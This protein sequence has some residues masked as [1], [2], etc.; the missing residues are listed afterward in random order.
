MSKLYIRVTKLALS[1][2][3]TDH[4][5]SGEP[6]HRKYGSGET[7]RAAVVGER[8]TLPAVSSMLQADEQ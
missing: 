5:I 6:D 7:E 2:H 4:G 3:R 8:A 1:P